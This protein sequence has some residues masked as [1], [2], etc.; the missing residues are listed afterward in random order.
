M[1]V[2]GGTHVWV[3]IKSCSTVGNANQ[4]VIMEIKIAFSDNIS[5]EIVYVLGTPN[6]V[7]ILI[8]QIKLIIMISFF[9]IFTV[10]PTL[11]Q[12]NSLCF[13]KN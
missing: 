13:H 4:S 6:W 3:C 11:P 7:Y 5:I 1:C 12:E 8:S 10:P 2:G 9:S